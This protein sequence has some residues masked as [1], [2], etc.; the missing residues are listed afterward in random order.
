MKFSWLILFLTASSSSLR[1]EFSISKNREA[2]CVVIQQIGA[3][4]AEKSAVRELTRTLHLITGAEF[5]VSNAAPKPAQ[6]AIVVG[7]GAVAAQLFPETDLSKL[8]S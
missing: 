6:S 5:S 3:T 4:E 1:A 7:P 2:A 8:G